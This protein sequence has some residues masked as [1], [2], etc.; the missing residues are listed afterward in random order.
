ME[1]SRPDAHAPDTR[2]FVNRCSSFDRF[3]RA[4]RRRFVVVRAVELAGMFA[5]AGG[6]FALI[7]AA[8]LWWQG[9]D[10]LALCGFALLAGAMLGLIVGAI[11]RPSLLE[12]AIEADRQLDLAD[13]LSTALS[14]RDANDPWQ[15]AVLTMA[16]ARCATLCAS[17][18]MVA[19]LGGRAWGGIGLSAALVVT[20]GVMSSIPR[21]TA[22]LDLARPGATAMSGATDAS[23]DDGAASA[24]TPSNSSSAAQ[25]RAA[26]DA[27]LS[28]E[29]AAE[30]SIEPSQVSETGLSNGERSA[31]GSGEGVVPRP[32]EASPRPP[33]GVAGDANAAIGRASSGDG[34]RGISPADAAAANAGGSTSSPPARDTAHTHVPPWRDAS[35]RAD[36]SVADAAVR[37]GKI[38]DQYR[39]VVR[40][41]FRAEQ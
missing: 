35:W 1:K 40:Q 22:A 39:E 25:A 3:V 32:S 28:S 27:T 8:A 23:A 6:A 26:D 10:A 20:V 24:V 2:V 4:V 15:G 21:E 5:T 41:Y 18:V 9:R 31:E 16:E 14:R 36:Q 17:S 29:Q 7:L 34:A 11:R 33:H 19:R 12:A 13:L 38:G 30:K 37:E